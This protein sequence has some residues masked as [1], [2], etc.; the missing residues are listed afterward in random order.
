MS[1]LVQAG[2]LS[3]YGNVVPIPTVGLSSPIDYSFPTQSV[4]LKLVNWIRLPAFKS[5]STALGS[6]WQSQQ[7]IF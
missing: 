4:S 5:L 2:G 7:V 3:N 6:N 1:S